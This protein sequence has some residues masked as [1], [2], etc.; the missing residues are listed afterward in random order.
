MK[1]NYTAIKLNNEIELQDYLKTQISKV[2]KMA[3]CNILIHQ[4]NN[5]DDFNNQNH[6]EV[7]MRKMHSI[8]KSGLRVS[9]YASIFGTMKL[10]GSSKDNIANKIVNYK[11]YNNQSFVN[12]LF[13][14]PKFI[15]IGEKSYEYSSFNGKSSADIPTELEAEYRKHGGLPMLRHAKCCLLDVIKG[16]DELPNYYL[17][18]TIYKEKDNSFYY[19]NPQTH[20]SEL[21]KESYAKFCQKIDEK[22]QAVFKSSQT[23]DIKQIIV[24]S[25]LNEEAM[26]DQEFLDFD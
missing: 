5:F 21:P 7:E 26:R 1:T 13:A 17:L 23:N 16:F 25:Y 24:K 10:L 19:I 14:I 6:K 20:L 3:E 22:L 8:I 9:Q 2:N 15:K 18:G 12:C 11:F 4:I